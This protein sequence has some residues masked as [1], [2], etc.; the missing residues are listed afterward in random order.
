MELSLPLAAQREAFVLKTM[1]TEIQRIACKPFVL[2]K[3][4]A[5]SHIQM[6]CLRLYRFTS[7]V[8][9]VVDP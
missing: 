1:T 8:S 5:Q 2:L 3:G 7:E 4:P 9:L 6:L